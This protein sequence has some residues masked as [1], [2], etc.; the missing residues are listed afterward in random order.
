MGACKNKYYQT[1]PSSKGDMGK[2]IME[3][4]LW[5]TWT[6]WIRAFPTPFPNK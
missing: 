2:N 5:K 6:R 4:F 1:T 3:L